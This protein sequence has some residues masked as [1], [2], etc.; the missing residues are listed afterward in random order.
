MK[1]LKELKRVV[2]EGRIVC[3]VF[4]DTLIVGV[5]GGIKPNSL[6]AYRFKAYVGFIRQIL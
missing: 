2:D 1:I 4:D 6:V 3:I 5:L